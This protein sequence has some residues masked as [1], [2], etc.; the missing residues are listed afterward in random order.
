MFANGLTMATKAWRGDLR[1]WLDGPYASSLHLLREKN[2]TIYQF[3][4]P[5]CCFM[6]HV[7]QCCPDYRCTFCLEFL[8]KMASA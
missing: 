2:V 7:T 8:R 4:V 6:K 3:A 1:K 5:H